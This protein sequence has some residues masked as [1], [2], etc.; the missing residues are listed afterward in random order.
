MGGNK[1]Q[2]ERNAA[3]HQGYLAHWKKEKQATGTWL[4]KE[5]YKKKTDNEGKK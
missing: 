1:K 3:D 4:S 2:P 5:E